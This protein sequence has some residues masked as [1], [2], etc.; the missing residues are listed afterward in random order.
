MC[1]SIFFIFSTLSAVPTMMLVRHALDAYIAR[2][3]DGLRWRLLLE[4]SPLPPC[5][6][7]MKIISSTSSLPKILKISSINP[8]HDYMILK[9]PN[10]FRWWGIRVS[11]TSPG[12]ER[13]NSKPF[14]AKTSMLSLRMASAAAVS[15][16]F[17]GITIS[18][19]TRTSSA[20][21]RSKLY[22]SSEAC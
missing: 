20:W 15:S 4:Q 8:G 13:S 12:L 21:S 10:Q 18:C 5:S 22:F 6:L 9:Q 7:N 1:S 3:L 16:S 11:R 19:P 17:C 2:T 14:L